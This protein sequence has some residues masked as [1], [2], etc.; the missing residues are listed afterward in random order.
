MPASQPRGHGHAIYC[1][2]LVSSFL[3]DEA[4]NIY[5]LESLWEWNEK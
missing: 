1:C 4:I 5:L 3:K 2:G